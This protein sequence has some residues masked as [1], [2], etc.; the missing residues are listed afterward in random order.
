M[1]VEEQVNH[2]IAHRAPV[3]LIL[4]ATKGAQGCVI[5]GFSAGMSDAE[6]GVDLPSEPE[7][8]R[9]ESPRRSPEERIPLPLGL[10][11]TS[12]IFGED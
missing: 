9:D 1:G 5:Y 12:L 4:M 6:L 2:L 8:A 11:T 10:T 3:F 7:L